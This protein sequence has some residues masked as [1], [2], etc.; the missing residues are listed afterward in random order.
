MSDNI[1]RM[2][3]NPR[4][5]K[6]VALYLAGHSATDAYLGAGYTTNADSAR[7]AA[8]RLLTNV[9]VAQAVETARI[10][11]NAN[12]GITADWYAKRVKLEAE[13]EGDGASHSARVSALKLAADLLGVSEKHELSGPGGTPIQNEH[14]HRFTLSAADLDAADELAP[15]VAGGDVPADGRPEPLHSPPATSPTAGVPAP[16]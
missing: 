11:A 6:F 1:D 7:K 9:D 2:A 15:S 13:R 3:L 4:Q 5:Q 14:E 10:A 16:G 8:A 12:N